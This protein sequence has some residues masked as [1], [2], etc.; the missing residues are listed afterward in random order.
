M[1]SSRAHT[2]RARPLFFENCLHLFTQGTQWHHYQILKGEGKSLIS[3]TL[4]T[5]KTRPNFTVNIY[6]SSDYKQQ[7]R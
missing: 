5:L 4:F 3:F 1:R 6:I 7:N 2:S